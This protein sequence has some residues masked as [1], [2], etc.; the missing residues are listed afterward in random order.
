MR[1]NLFG[2]GTQSESPAVTAQKRINCRVEMRQEQDRTNY[3]VT[4]R[5]GLKGWSSTLADAENRGMWAVNT[6]ST[7]TLFVVQGSSLWAFTYS[8]AVTFIGSLQTSSGNVSMVDDGVN[9]MIVDGQFGYYYNMVTP[10]GVNIIVDGN[11]MANP[12]TVTWQDTYFIVAGAGTVVNQ[13]QFS[14][15]A[16]VTTWPAVNIGFTESSPNALQAGIADHSVLNLFTDVTA[17]FWQDSGSPDLP[18]SKIPGSAAEFGLA[19]PFSLAKFDNSVAGLFKSKMGGVIA[20]R[21]NGF[22]L[23]KISDADMDTILSGYSTVAD[24][25][26][27]AFMDRGHPMYV[28]NLPTAEASWMYDGKTQIWSELQAPDGSRFWATKFAAFLN[29]LLVSDRTSGNIYELDSNTYADNGDEIPCELVSRHIWNDDRFVGISKIQIDVESGTGLVS[30]QGQTPV[31][32]LRVSKDGGRSFFSV[33]FSSIGKVGE[34]TQ[35]VTWNSLGAAR[36]WVLSLR[37][38]DPVKFVLTGASAEITGGSF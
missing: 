24:A 13:F 33:G 21:M 27:F 4:R 19:A 1:V 9:L 14:N 34:F 7:P 32:D 17:E 10:A 36:D 12:K 30:G 6:L 23:A 2:I 26:G 28:I 38:T 16:D 5:A 37:I 22:G 8:S 18:Y 11:F 20:A 31:L 35:R 29:R 3:V 25:T 15:G